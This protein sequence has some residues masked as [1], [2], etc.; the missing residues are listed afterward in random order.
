[1]ETY[2]NTR[3]ECAVDGVD[4]ALLVKP[5]VRRRLEVKGG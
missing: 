4:R 3:A 2:T 1:M 5:A